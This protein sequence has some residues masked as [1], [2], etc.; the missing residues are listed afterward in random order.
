MSGYGLCMCGTDAGEET[1]MEYIRNEHN[2]KIAEAVCDA[3]HENAAYLSEID[4]AIGDGD[5]GV[6]M[7]KGFMMAKQR[8]REDMSFSESMKTISRTLVMDIG[9][10][11]GP[12]YGTMFS[13]IAK[14]SKQ[15][16]KLTREIFLN[17]L[18][19][20]LQGLQELAGAKEGDKTLIDTLAP[21]T[22]AYEQALKEGSSYAACLCALQK[23]AEAGK[24]HTKELVAKIGRAARLGERSRGYLDAGATS[25]CII[26]TTMAEQ[27][28]KAIVKE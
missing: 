23:G 8:L 14:A 5:H 26:L 9:G 11:M 7:N 13:R 27:M 10:S 19:D 3:I 6:N 25:C 24:E 21:A 16:E 22:R 18:Q 12:I 1:V 4:G 2:V 28:C 17:A 20:A 15:E